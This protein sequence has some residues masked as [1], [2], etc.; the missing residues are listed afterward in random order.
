MDDHNTG[1][2]AL[3]A[4]LVTVKK[5][6][7]PVTWAEVHADPGEALRAWDQR[8]HGIV[9]VDFGQ[10][11][12]GMTGARFTQRLREKSASV[13]IILLAD[14][15]AEH[16]HNWARLN[17]ATDVVARSGKAIAACFPK[18]GQPRPPEFSSSFGPDE[19]SPSD[20]A[21]VI[22]SALKKYGQLGPIRTVLIQDS[23]TRLTLK[24][25]HAPTVIELADAVATQIDN[26][27]DRT[28][29]LNA[30]KPRKK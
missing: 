16:H 22:D 29:F 10:L 5:F 26:P 14:Q 12:G 23:I 15:V 21:R 19:D 7:S 2:R 13:V 4:L 20:V 3:S 25:G 6:S 27:A 18:H 11:G 9:F 8:R 28:A 1:T 30:I 17:G 24:L